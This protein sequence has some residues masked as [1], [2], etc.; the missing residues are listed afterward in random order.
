MNLSWKEIK[1]SRNKYLL[2]ELILVLLMFMV[3]FLS[4][5][6]NGLA[7]AVSSAVENTNAA[8]FVVSEDANDLITVS[9]LDTAVLEEVKKE[10]NSQVS[11]LNIKRMNLNLKG[12]DEKYDVTYFAIDTT[13][14]LNPEVEEGQQLEETANQIVLDQSYEDDGVEIGDIVEDS[15]TGVEMTI[16]GFTKDRTYGHIA[17]GYVST[18]TYTQIQTEINPTYEEYAQAIVIESDDVASIDIDGVEVA[19]RSDIVDNLPGYASEQ[20]TIR[21]ILWVL[22]VVSA[23]ILGVFF[24]VLTIQKLKQFGVLKA[25]GM[26]MSEIAGILLA[27]MLFL[28]IVGVMVGNALALG[29]AALLPASM[30]FYIEGADVTLV[31][32]VFVVIAVASSLLSIVK[33]AKVD[34]IIMIGENE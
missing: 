22:V 18:A 29:L 17:A 23:A 3:I 15:A 14:F 28:A 4:G 1:H 33:V 8:Y 2:I 10:T 32:V 26:K 25:I 20:T 12:S 6:A 5:L 27:Q 34:P 7:R 24:Y 21:M 11:P 31:S 30:P 16:V 9:K 19:P 13:G